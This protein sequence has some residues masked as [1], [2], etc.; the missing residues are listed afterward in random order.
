MLH[1]QN[2]K[3]KS[4]RVLAALFLARIG[5]AVQISI[6][7]DVTRPEVNPRF[8]S[9]LTRPPTWSTFLNQTQFAALRSFPQD[10]NL[11]IVD[12]QS[13]L[14]N[15]SQ[16]G[17]VVWPVWQTIFAP[18]FAEVTTYLAEN[19]FYMT[20]LWGYVPGS[21]PG[22]EMWQAFTP[23][24][25]NLALAG[26]ILGERWLGMD[27]GE[28]D[29]RYV[30]SYANQHTPLN[31]P[32]SQQRAFFDSHFQAM[33]SQLGGRVVALQSLTFAHSMAQSGAFTVVGCES[34]QALINA[35][36]F[37]AVARGAGKQYG[38]LYFGNVSIYNRFGYKHYPS[39]GYGGTRVDGGGMAT[40]QR[41]LQRPLLKPT[42]RTGKQRAQSQLAEK[43][44][45][46]ATYTCTNQNEGGAVCG[47]SLS[48]MAK[49][50]FA[51][52]R[53]PQAADACLDVW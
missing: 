26:S 48:L 12:Y 10:D 33:Y 8:G 37:Y 21:G 13:T 36:L 9:T 38:T 1:H 31:A 42:S 51:Q 5:V 18:N 47:T 17:H 14:S 11:T 45:T 35:Q 22:P 23:P 39:G 6:F 34:G 49:L 7:P 20:D 50:I 43:S 52:V 3:L 46:G 16:L 24:P 15:Y 30:S 40:P 32:G 41:S 28:Q 27:V 53:A 44:P 4:S 25:E 2:S 19:N 29:G